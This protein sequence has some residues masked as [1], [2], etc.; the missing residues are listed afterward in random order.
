MTR[1]IRLGVDDVMPA[2]EAVLAH[3]GIPEDAE[4]S[5]RILRLHECAEEA[6]A[7][8]ARPV[9]IIGELEPD[10]FASVFEGVGDNAEDAVVGS[11]FPAADRLALYA[12]TIGATVSE[13]IEALFA[14]NDFAPGSM[15]DSVASQAADRAAEALAAWYHDHLLDQGR[16]A[17]EDAVMGYSPGYC[18]WHITGQ[19]ALFE[20]L[21]PGR[22]GISLN[23]SCMMSPLKSVSGILVAANPSVHVF[24]PRFS[25]CADCKQR[26]C[27]DRMQ[28]LRAAARGV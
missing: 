10:A 15:L 6:F 25:Y 23:G 27:I 11:L 21:Q 20:H 28:P 16:L 1:T 4:V 7:A 13:R 17:P 8:C 3:Q 19:R 18:G 5:A 12:A 26:P 14:D 2:R 22:I 24:K 9:G